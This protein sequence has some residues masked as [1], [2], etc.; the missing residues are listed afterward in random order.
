MAADSLPYF[1]ETGGNLILALATPDLTTSATGQVQDMLGQ[2]IRSVPY[3]RQLFLFD[4]SGNLIAE[5][6]PVEVNASTLTPEE[7]SGVKLALRGIPVQHYVIPPM[8]EET[9]AQV[10]FLS[11]VQSGEGVVTGVLLGRTDFNSNPFV[12]P[13]IQALSGIQDMGGEGMILSEDGTIL[14]SPSVSQVMSPYRG[15]LPGSTS[16]YNDISPNNT[17]RY[18]YY[19]PVAGRPWA[20]VLAVPAQ[21]AQQMALDIAIPLLIMLATFT[22]LAFLFLRVGLTVSPPLYGCSPRKPLSYRWVNSTIQWRCA[23]LTKWGS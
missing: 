10:T 17:R 4:Q 18:V 7:T 11:P 8:P 13:A 20:I 5:Y 6:P 15:S 19:R 9:S 1:L 16:F 22:A 12:Q 23:A 3:F 21:L 2:R 14:Y